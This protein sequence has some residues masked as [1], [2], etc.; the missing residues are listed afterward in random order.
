MQKYNAP[1]I[2]TRTLYCKIIHKMKNP[3]GL[4]MKSDII[5]K[6]IL[7]GFSSSAGSNIFSKKSNAS[8]LS[9]IC[10]II[11]FAMFVIFC[12]IFI[13]RHLYHFLKRLCEALNLFSF[14]NIFT[15][16][17]AKFWYL[18]DKYQ[19]YSERYQLHLTFFRMNPSDPFL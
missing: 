11:G 4:H 18:S 12:P 17:S 5:I 10:L 19:Y 15:S 3:T 2:K 7:L 1:V 16:F 6:Y 8:R 14:K 13:Y 9:L